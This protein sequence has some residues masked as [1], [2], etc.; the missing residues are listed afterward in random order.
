MSDEID[1][2]ALANQICFAAYS[3]SHAFARRYK[4]LLS[5][6]GV[7]YPQYLC[8]L[9]LWEQ[10]GLSVKAIG[11]RLLLD[12]GTLT[13]LL[14]RLEGMGL[15]KRQRDGADERVVRISLSARGRE[16]RA[17]AETIPPALMQATGCSAHELTALREGLLALR[18]NLLAE[19]GGEA[20]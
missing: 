4:P 2:L 1:R 9:V 10:D 13:P 16:L 12:S 5:A 20:E 18:D 15:I 17:T 6:L 3:A 7:T 11:E 19:A 14:K 8:L